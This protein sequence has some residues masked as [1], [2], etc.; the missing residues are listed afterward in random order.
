M[1][2][3]QVLLILIL[4]IFNFNFQFFSINVLSSK[5][6]KYFIK[7]SP[8]I[9]EPIEFGI[10]SE[11]L[12]AYDVYPAL[13]RASL[14]LPMYNEFMPGFDLAQLEIGIG[15]ALPGNLPAVVKSTLI[16]PLKANLIKSK[17]NQQWKFNRKP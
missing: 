5:I 7:E 2:F 13:Q 9:P 12:M 3:K 11:P 17:E 10:P 16:T 4:V 15:K 6:K 8:K 1:K 14:D